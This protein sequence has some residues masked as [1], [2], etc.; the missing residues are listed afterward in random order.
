M[1]IDYSLDILIH[2]FVFICYRGRILDLTNIKTNYTRVRGFDIEG[3]RHRLHKNNILFAVPVEKMPD[4][5]P[6]I[7]MHSSMR[8]LKID[9]ENLIANRFHI[10]EHELESTVGD[11]VVLVTR[12]GHVIHGELQAF[13]KYHL[14]MRVGNKVVLVYRHG[15]FNFNKE[16]VPSLTETNTLRELRKKKPQEWVKASRLKKETVPNRTEGND[17]NEVRKKEHPERVEANQPKKE[18]VPSQTKTNDLHEL[19]KIREEW[20]ELSRENNFEEGIKG[21]LTAL[22]PDRAHFIYELLQNAEDAGASE[23][24]FA[25]E[26]D[27]LKFEHNGDQLFT[28]DDIKSITNFGF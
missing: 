14:F 22:Y 28:I 18:T 23:V 19:R 10:E 7:E 15:L 27:K 3:K 11:H 26:V 17:R 2:R 13:D 24:Q 20:V 9:Q 5:Q 12:G 8:N 1:Q 16:T 6:H 4:V 21:L 25:L